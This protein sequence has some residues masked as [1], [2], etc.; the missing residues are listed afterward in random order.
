MKYI[1]KDDTYIHDCEVEFAEFTVFLATQ[2]FYANIFMRGLQQTLKGVGIV[3]DSDVA[4]FMHHVQ[5]LSGLQVVNEDKPFENII[6]ADKILDEINK[7]FPKDPIVAHLLINQKLLKK[8]GVVHTLMN[9]GKTIL[10]EN[11]GG[12]Y[13]PQRK[14]DLVNMLAGKGANVV[15]TTNDPYILQAISILK[16]TGT[17]IRTYTMHVDNNRLRLKSKGDELRDLFRP[18]T[19]SYRELIWGDERRD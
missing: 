2:D 18:L 12:G 6:T 16:T 1:I 7:A 9:E 19:K 4:H 13:S 17:K 14:I 5:K 11:L 8:G 15:I 10:R 3:P